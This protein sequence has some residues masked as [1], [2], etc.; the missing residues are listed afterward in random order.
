MKKP[1]DEL[2]NG[3][4]ENAQA[5]CSGRPAFGPYRAGRPKIN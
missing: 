2:N 4:P 3:S 5:T 1:K